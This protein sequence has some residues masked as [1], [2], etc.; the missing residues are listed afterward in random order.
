VI[1]AHSHVLPQIDDGPAS[2]EETMAMVHQAERD[3]I[4]EIAITHHILS[5]LDFQK[6]N[7]IISKFEELK[8][9]ID[10]EKISI[11]IHLGAELYSQP[12]LDLS[13]KIAT[14]NNNKKYFLVEFPMQGIPKF[15]P[16][17]FFDI[18]ASKGMIPIIAHPE[19][20]MGIIRN[21]ERAIEFVQ[22][23]ALLQMNAG[24]IVGRHGEPVRDAAMVLLNS[25]LIHL[26]G[27]DGHNTRRRPMKLRDA[28]NLIAEKW[29]EERARALFFDNPRKVIAGEQFAVPEPL[30]IQPLRNGIWETLKK[31]FHS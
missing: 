16:E 30:P 25:N 24:S 15:A 20:N 29:G 31:V 3:G 19:R 8:K 22:R 13:H 21:P 11:K 2:W 1:D 26:V 17:F 6:E 18:I 7:E 9:R 28:M 23:G 10:I 14:Y 5:N 12:D 27:S 4:T